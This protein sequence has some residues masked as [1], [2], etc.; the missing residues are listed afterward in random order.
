MKLSSKSKLFEVIKI[1]KFLIKK[2]SYPTDFLNK[3]DQSF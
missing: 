1:I 2:I 3:S